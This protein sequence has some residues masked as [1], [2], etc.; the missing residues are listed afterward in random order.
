MT[1]NLS[2]YWK[3]WLPL[4]KTSA[5][6]RKVTHVRV[7]EQSDARQI[8]HWRYAPDFGNIGWGGGGY[9]TMYP[10][11]DS[12]VDE[13]FTIY[14]DR[15]CVR[16]I[17]K[18][19]PELAIW[20]DPNHTIVKGYTLEADSIKPLAEQ[21]MEAANLSLTGGSE[22]SYLYDGYESSRRSYV[23]SCLKKGATQPLNCTLT[24]NPSG[25]IY[26]PVLE[27][28]NWG[29]ADVN[30][31]CD[32]QALTDPNL[33]KT[34]YVKRL[35]SMDLVVWLKKQSGTSMSITLTPSGGSTPINGAPQVNAGKDK[36]I[37]VPGGTVWPYEVTLAGE[38]KDDGLPNDSLTL[39]WSQ[40]SGPSATIDNPAKADTVVRLTTTGEYTFKLTVNDGQYSKE[41]SVLVRLSQP[42]TPSISPVA[43]WDFNEG[44]GTTARERVGQ[45]DS[46][47]S[48]NYTVWEAGVSGASLTFDGYTS[49]VT[50]PKAQA[51]VLDE[52]FTIEA[53][54]APQTYSWNWTA[55]VNQEQNR[56][57]GYFFGIDYRGYPGLHL[58][59]G[60]TWYECNSSQPI[61][62]LQWTHIAGTF[63]KANGTVVVYVN[64]VPTGTITVASSN[65]VRAD[66]DLL[67]GKNCTRMYPRLTERS[68]SK[69]PSDMVFDG[70][71]DEVKIYNQALNQSQINEL[72]SATE[73]VEKTALQYREMPTNA[74][75]PGR[76]RASYTRLD[77]SPQWDNLWRV[78]DHPDVIV[79]FD[80]SPVRMV[81]WRGTS[82][83]PAWVSEN[84]IWV[85]DQGPESFKGECFE[86]M[87][88]KQL[89]YS[90][91]RILENTAARA[92]VHWRT[93]LP[94]VR[95]SFNNIEPNTGWPEWA[96]EY[97][98]IYPDAVAVRYQEVW[99]DGHIIE[100]QQGEVLHQPGRTP[101]DDIYLNPAVTFRTF[102][103]VLSSGSQGFQ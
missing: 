55:I 95:Y 7:I 86:M 94:S 9:F 100:L 87:S 6:V 42:S 10:G 57:T 26:N 34:G 32:G 20:N 38:V 14:P 8:V 39:V 40:V 76:F 72:F 78:G 91:V 59:V 58:N 17:R 77:Y 47:V 23:L 43:W 61:P 68:P 52:A 11:Y 63:D 96:D 18:G 16:T 15:I 88:D 19:H 93:A 80:E 69:V 89:R 29:D 36:A 81:F 44:S 13:Y 37:V 46:V 27:V 98:Y 65:L 41:D 103:D 84:D 99:T 49:C 97:Y 12:Y 21:R 51:P 48:G 4:L 31:L 3:P 35:D 66:V 50:H 30:I 64:G 22:T 71:I 56:Q 28:R 75:F 92:V 101:E 85:S 1:K 60:N 79:T 70:R 5:K 25:S 74:P 82:Y 62:L 83:C 2:S 24:A 102:A 73:P 53:W 90:H 54:I 45:N 67:I 33:F